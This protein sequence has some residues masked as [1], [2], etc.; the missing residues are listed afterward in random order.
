MD[1]RDIQNL[2]RFVA[3]SGASEVKLEMEDIK[4]TIKTSGEES[5]PETVFVQQPYVAQGLPQTQ[6]PVTP[7][8]PI[9]VS[10]PAN[11]V[12]TKEHDDEE[13]GKYITIKSPIIGTFYRRQAP[14]KPLF[15]EV[16]DNIVQGQTLCVIEAMKL[17]NEI[18]SEVSGKLV[19]VLVDDASPVEYDQPLFL[20]DPS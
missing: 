11:I 15:V 13:N 19:K 14:N 12:A 4:I 6:I 2:I 8:I 9:P 3:K 5:K 16:G 20:V 1:L 7:T 10:D 17:F 18:E